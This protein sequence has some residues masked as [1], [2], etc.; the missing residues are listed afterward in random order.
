MKKLLLLLV[1]VITMLPLGNGWAVVE[2]YASTN[3][4][5]LPRVTDVR[6]HDGDASPKDIITGSSIN[7]FTRGETNSR[8]DD[9]VNQNEEV[10]IAPADGTVKV[11]R[12]N[13]KININNFVTGV[14]P[15]KNVFPRELRHAFRTI[16]RKEGGEADVIQDKVKKENFMFVTCPEFQLPYLEQ[17]A[18]ELDYEWVK[19][20]NDGAGELYYQAKFRP[21]RDIQEGVVQLYRGPEGVWAF[22]DL[23]NAVYFNDQPAVIPLFQKGL[24]DADIPPNQV[25][26]DVTIYEININNDTKLGLDYIAWKN[27]PG[28]NL[29]GLVWGNQ[30]SR[31]NLRIEGDNYITETHPFHFR[32]AG[33]NAVFTAAYFD[34]LQ[35]KGKA[36]VLT[37]GTVLSKSGR[38]AEI[39]AVDEVLALPIVT[40]ESPSILVATENNVPEVLANEPIAFPRTLNVKKYSSIDPLNPANRIGVFVGFLPYIGTESMELAIAAHISNVA[41][42]SP[43]GLPIINQRYVESFV[44][45]KNG[46]PFVLAGVKRKNSVQTSNKV[47]FLGDIPVLGWLFGGETNTNTENEI[48]IVL[49]PKFIIGTQSDLAF[50]QEAKTVISQA[51]GKAPLKPPSISFGFDQWLLDQE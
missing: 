8:V 49:K 18:K 51:T 4:G 26:L 36:K 3:N 17:A 39:A 33:L 23:N 37:Q 48:V 15:L 20:A 38:Y 25:A 11:L 27:G 46:E 35:S 1:M 10:K 5:A 22:D 16:V 43:C 29:W 41:G 7:Q 2:D 50:P 32:Y 9:Y 31:S 13:Q 40:G 24:S 47:P 34:F 21:I 6:F 42:Q 30:H 19:H 28:R 45:L 44:R 14:L 12:T